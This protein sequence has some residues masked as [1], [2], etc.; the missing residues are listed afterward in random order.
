[1][2]P[3][4]IKIAPPK[5]KGRFGPVRLNRINPASFFFLF[6]MTGIED[7]PIARFERTLQLHENSFSLQAADFAEK[8]APLFSKAA[9]DQLLVINSAQPAGVKTAREG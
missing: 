9:M 2:H 1:M 8:N 4:Q 3:A 5:L 7:H 6:R